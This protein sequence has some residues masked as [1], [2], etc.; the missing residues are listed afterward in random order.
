MYGI[1]QYPPP[2]VEIGDL[3]QF[4]LFKI[5]ESVLHFL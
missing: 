3:S 2:E 5:T 4:I 1:P